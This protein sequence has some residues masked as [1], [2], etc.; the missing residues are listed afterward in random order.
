MPAWT[1]V[2]IDSW[3]AAAGITAGLVFRGVNKGDV[4]IGERLSTQGILRAVARYAEAIAPHDLRR[5]LREAGLSKAAPSWI[6]SSSRWATPRFKRP[7]GIS[8][9]SRI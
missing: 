3:A 2:A 8:A 6:R 1:K 7:N 5:D 9:C 4:A